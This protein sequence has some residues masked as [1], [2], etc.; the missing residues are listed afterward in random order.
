M[1]YLVLGLI[2]YVALVSILFILADSMS[3]VKR[4]VAGMLRLMAGKRGGLFYV[5]NGRRRYI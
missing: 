3:V 5:D 1:I 4:V 2:T